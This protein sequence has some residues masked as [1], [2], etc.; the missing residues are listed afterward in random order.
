MHLC[1]EHKFILKCTAAIIIALY[2]FRAILKMLTKPFAHM[3]QTENEKL[4]LN[5]NTNK[6]EKF[7]SILSSASVYLSVI[8]PSYNEESRLPVML[9]EAIEYLEMRVKKD[10]KFSYEIV[11]VDDGSKD[12]TSKVGLEYSA[13]HGSDKIRVLTL[14][15]NRGKGGAV[16]MGVMKS[17]GSLILFADAD[18]ATKFSDFERLENS[19]LKDSSNLETDEI[20]SCGSRRHLQGDSVAERTLFRTILMYGFHFLVWFLCVKGIRD[21]QCGFKLLTRP[22]ALKTF[23]NLHV[24]RWAFDV[25]LLYIAETFKIK[26][27]EI[28]VNW[29]ECEGSK[30][31]FGSWIQMGKDLLSI[32]LH[33]MLGAWKLDRN[34]RIAD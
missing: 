21:T 10:K 34:I 25:D 32:R 16:R 13:K 3:A 22:A 2:L 14:E 5:P 4:F 23:S 1:C 18:G 33:Y 11:I 28:D 19:I 15:T 31:T 8:V 6:K 29:K 27:H 26:V 9:D 24:L 12:K 20:I 30:V 17:R 7:P